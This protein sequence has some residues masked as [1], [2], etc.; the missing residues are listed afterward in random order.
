MTTGEQNITLSTGKTFTYKLDLNE[1][2]MEA[3][4]EV[5]EAPEA[6]DVISFGVAA[7]KCL[8]LYASLDRSIRENALTALRA[9]INAA[10]EEH[11]RAQLV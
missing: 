2:I 5:P 6:I 4:A 11:D 1:R 9:A 3:L 7:Y 8:D 10:G